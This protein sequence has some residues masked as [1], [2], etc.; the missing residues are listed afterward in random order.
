MQLLRQFCLQGLILI[1]PVKTHDLFLNRLQID[2]V[3][4]RLESSLIT[5]AFTHSLTNQ[6]RLRQTQDYLHKI[7]NCNVVGGVSF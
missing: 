2:F 6:L 3:A 5:P 4:K 1:Y 7:N